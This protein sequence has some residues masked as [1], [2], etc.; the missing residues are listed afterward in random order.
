MMAE[1]T[2][3]VQYDTRLARAWMHLLRVAAP[4]IGV[5]LASRLADYTP[6]LCRWR[7]LPNGRWHWVG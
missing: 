7:S 3:V 5:R 1:V 6:R 2:F 4:V